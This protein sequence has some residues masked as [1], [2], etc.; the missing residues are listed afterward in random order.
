MIGDEG[1][2]LGV[3][4][5]PSVRGE[6]QDGRRTE[7]VFRGEEDAEMVESSLEFCAGRTT[8]GTVP[9]LG[10]ADK[11]PAGNGKMW[12]RLTNMSS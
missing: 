7:R 1:A 4:F 6:H 12:I 11:D 8:D 10:I 5:K 9:F 2:C 3:E